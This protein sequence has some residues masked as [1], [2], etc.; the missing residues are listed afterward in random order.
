MERKKYSKALRQQFPAMLD[1]WSDSRAGFASRPDHPRRTAITE[2]MPSSPYPPVLWK[3]SAGER[4]HRRLQES[5]GDSMAYTF[6]SIDWRIRPGWQDW[7][8]KFGCDRAERRSAVFLVCA[9][10][11]YTQAPRRLGRVGAQPPAKQ[12]HGRGCIPIPEH[13]PHLGQTAV[14]ESYRFFHL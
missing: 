4:M 9:T 11:G 8:K 10:D 5:T 6:V 12:P 3:S 13:W 1:S 7:P 2:C 14:L